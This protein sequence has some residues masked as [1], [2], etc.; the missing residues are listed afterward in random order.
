M[1]LT[2][3]LKDIED[4][5]APRLGLDVIERAVYYHLFRHTHL[6]GKDA[7][8]FALLP[9]GKAIGISESSVRE[10]IRS[11]NEKGCV[12]IQERS[13]NGHLVR[14]FLPSEIPGIV[15]AEQRAAPIDVASLDFFTDRKYV[16]AL[17]HREDGRCFYCLCTITSDNCAL[18]HVIAQVHGVDNSYRNVVAACHGCNSEKQAI[19]AATFLRTRY[20]QGLVSSEEL[21]NRLATLD[22]LQTGQLIPEI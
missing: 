10:R 17:V 9:V 12:S 6:L 1:D 5:L 3:T 13:K 20:R 15:P 19:D 4:H 16:E 7:G 14:V 21:Q 8:L 22:R 11:M 18:D 2:K